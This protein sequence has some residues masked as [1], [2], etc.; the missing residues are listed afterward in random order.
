ME[1]IRERGTDGETKSGPGPR[2]SELP[3]DS[4]GGYSKPRVFSQ[5]DYASGDKNPTDGRCTALSTPCIR[6]PTTVSV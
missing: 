6:L 2:R 3:T 5:Y 1:W 4:T